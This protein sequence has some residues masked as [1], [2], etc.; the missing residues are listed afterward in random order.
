VYSPK[1]EKKGFYI[2]PS[3]SPKKEGELMWCKEV[4]YALGLSGERGISSTTIH[5]LA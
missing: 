1:K 2:P 4:T 5:G 3:V